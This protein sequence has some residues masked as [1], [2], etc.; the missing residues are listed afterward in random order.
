MEFSVEVDEILDQR[1]SFIM[2]KI[3]EGNQLA[4]DLAE[5]DKDEPGVRILDT[6]EEDEDYTIVK[7]THLLNL[8]NKESSKKIEVLLTDFGLDRHNTEQVATKSNFVS[9]NN[10]VAINRVLSANAGELKETFE[11]ESDKFK[12]QSNNYKTCDKEPIANFEQSDN[13]E[14]I[15]I[16][17]K[18][19]YNVPDSKSNQ[20]IQLSIIIEKDVYVPWYKKMFLCCGTRNYI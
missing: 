19:Q 2:R 15:S 16:N 4:K 10:A 1:Y 13:D 8:Y 7:K 3:L 9:N 18:N 12:V 20:S 5:R 17:G 6:N 14:S 11:T